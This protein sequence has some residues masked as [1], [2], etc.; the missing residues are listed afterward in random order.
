MNKCYRYLFDGSFAA[1]AMGPTKTVPVGSSAAIPLVDDTVLNLK[2]SLVLEV[3]SLGTF[4]N[5]DSYS[6]VNF[7]PSFSDCRDDTL[8]VPV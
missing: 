7:D 6:I 2:D 1:D 4:S 8:T 3:A 5:V